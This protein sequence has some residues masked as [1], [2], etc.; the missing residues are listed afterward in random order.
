MISIPAGIIPSAIISETTLT[1]DLAYNTAVPTASV[2]FSIS[3][4]LESA[5][6]DAGFMGNVQQGSTK[7]F[8]VLGEGVNREVISITSIDAVN[9]QFTIADRGRAGTVAKNHVAGAK[10]EVHNSRPDGLFADQIV[11]DVSV[12]LA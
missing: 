4:G 10:I 12:A 9:N 1:A 7:R 5:L 6:D 11:S 2:G 8:L 3:G